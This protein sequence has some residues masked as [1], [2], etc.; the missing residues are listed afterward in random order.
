MAL[1]ELSPDTTV[2]QFK[3]V[4]VKG[5]CYRKGSAIITSFHEQ[6]VF[7]KVVHIFKVSEKL[8]FVYQKLDTVEF[9]KPLNSFKVRHCAEFSTIE[10]NSLPYNHKLHFVQ[11]VETHVIVPCRS[12]LSTQDFNA[13]AMA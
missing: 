10:A 9:R 6:P 7:G 3:V 2:L 8:V 5:V 4:T 11:Q 1:Q 12:F 13:N